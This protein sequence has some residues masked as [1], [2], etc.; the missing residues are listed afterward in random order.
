MEGTAQ[1]A[2]S[3]RFGAFEL[4]ARSGELRKH[5][6]RIKLQDQPRQILVLLLERAGEIVTREEIQKRLWP[7]NTFVDFD[8]AI[9]SAVRKL[10]DALG[11]TAENSR[12]VETLARRGYRFVAP[13]SAK[14]EATPVP[15]LESTP[16]R[17][18][19]SARLSR[20]PI[21]ALAVVFAALGAALLVW[22][23]R[24]SG[25]TERA[26]IRVKPLTANAGF[27]SHPSFSP[28]GTRVAYVWSD[29]FGK[30]DI[31]VK[32]IGTG[33]PVR[34]T[35]VPAS[36][37]AA[38]SPDGADVSE[39][40][41]RGSPAP[42]SSPAWSPDGRWI[43]ALRH[44]GQ[45]SA[46]IVIPSSGGRE[47]ELSRV[48]QT[49]PGAFYGPM[50]AWSGDGKFLFTSERSGHDS[51]FVIIR[52]SV[53]TG[54][55]YP[56]TSPPRAIY[57]DLG[58]A[59][60]PDGRSLVFVRARAPTGDL[61]IVSLT[62]TTPAAGK[63]R[64]VTF[65]E[66]PLSTPA[67]TSD[68]RELI[69]SSERGGRRELWRVAASGSGKPVRLSGVGENAVA[70]AIAPRDQRL[71][72]E[73]NSLSR[74]LW[75]IPI[76]AGKGGTPVRVTS[77]T[78]NDTYPDYS[79]DGR[80]IAFESDRSGVNEIWVCDAD[81]ANAVQLT[82]FGKGWSG[83]PRWSPDGRT[84]AF[85]STVGGN[86]NIHLIRSEGGRPIR[87]TAN[88]GENT[89]P[90]WSRNGQWI[91]FASTRTGRSETWRIRPD[92]TSETQVTTDGGYSGAESSDGQYI[93]YKNEPGVAGSL[94]K[95][96]VA[97]GPPSKV[98][99]SVL[100]RLVTVTERGI[101]FSCR[102]AGTPTKELRFL[103]FAGDKVRDIASLDNLEYSGLSPDERWA[104]VSRPEV[105]SD[106]LMLVENFR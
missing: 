101:Y 21:T 8:N 18:A 55:Q 7:D 63:P 46:V 51:A 58:P 74:S 33:D 24:G 30:N 25:T 17:P 102:P 84:I 50:L 19:K 41:R 87:L 36:S 81:G 4:D 57:G 15:A 75:K 91:Y 47:R 12:F 71:V 104:L 97:G 49:F 2:P 90:S 86:W 53:E 44:E 105:S 11:D 62:G 85:D 42:Y 68:G 79:P 64:Q 5:G 39:T 54:E 16:A 66:V 10:R 95:K 32:L 1:R 56:I 37:S 23:V 28:D 40:L 34:I 96:P 52:V 29:Q 35:Q 70:V 27:E 83:S 82:T 65:D 89:T 93:Y 98:I 38:G 22:L 67:W 92:G 60:S 73:R 94:W 77:T 45:K 103:D 78:A 48:T 9:N 6:V 99:D 61:F 80:R 59:V 31:Y 100:R 14:C 88:R 106:N 20:W 43:A 13:V 3:Y 76:E 72:Y 26:D 69:F